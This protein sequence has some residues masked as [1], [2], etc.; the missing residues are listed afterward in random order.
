[1]VTKG[2]FSRSLSYFAA[3]IVCALLLLPAAS[4]SVEAQGLC[5]LLDGYSPVISLPWLQGEMRGRVI[6]ERIISG[7]QTIPN[8]GQDWDLR[9]TFNLT[10]GRLFMDYMLRVQLSRLSARLYYEMRDFDATSPFQNVPGQPGSSARFT[11]TGL[12]LGADLDIVQRCRTRFG[13]DMDFDLFAPDFT[14]SVETPGGK[15]ITGPAALTMGIHGVYNPVMNFW[16]ISPLLEVRARWPVSE[17]KV[18]DWEIS[19]GLASPETMLGTMAI[20]GGYRRTSLQFKD[21]QVFQDTAASTDF[22]VVLGGWF[23]DLIYYY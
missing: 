4:S 6:W 22:D 10:G 15:S 5:G 13:V 8:L 19:A 20:T 7:K 18:T 1:M 11:Y 12:R 23:A 14:E 9:D 2:L 3:A 21:S 17:T 16:G